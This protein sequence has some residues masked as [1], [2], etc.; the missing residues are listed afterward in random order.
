MSQYIQVIDRNGRRA[1]RV[2]IRVFSRSKRYYRSAC[3]N[4]FN[5]D[6]GATVLIASS[7]GLQV[8]P[9]CQRNSR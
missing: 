1:H 4:N 5:T 2:H 6:S 9:R 7:D 8:C 3:N